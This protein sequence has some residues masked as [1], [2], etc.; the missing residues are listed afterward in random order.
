M[1]ASLRRDIS[2]I[3]L[4]IP[5]LGA[6]DVEEGWNVR[7]TCL[8]VNVSDPEDLKRAPELLANSLS[9]KKSGK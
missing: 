2:V 8:P 1:K 6:L 3:S 9:P 5:L 7:L 4:F